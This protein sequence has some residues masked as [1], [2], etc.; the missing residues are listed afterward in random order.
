M[1]IRHFLLAIYLFGVSA[2]AYAGGFPSEL[3]GVELGSDISELK[4]VKDTR[5]YRTVSIVPPNPDG[6]LDL[7]LAN[8]DE[9]K[10]VV[11]IHAYKA[12]LQPQECRVLRNAVADDLSK[13]Y[14]VVFRIK[15]RESGTEYYYSEF[16]G[17]AIVID[18]RNNGTRLRVALAINRDAG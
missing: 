17:K 14:D 4:G 5:A 7:Y 12:N 11:G 8:Y 18:C 1:H 3:F 10:K 9:G 13:K 15:K 16:E 2:F 6:R